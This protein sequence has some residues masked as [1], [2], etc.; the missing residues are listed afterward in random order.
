MLD[1]VSIQLG[2]LS[3][4][5]V[6]AQ[7]HELVHTINATYW[8]ICNPAEVC[9]EAYMEMVKKRCKIMEQLQGSMK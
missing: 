9:S 5:N 4:Y 1:K 7:H 2:A 6:L 3:G 8:I